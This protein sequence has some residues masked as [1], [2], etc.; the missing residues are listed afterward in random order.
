MNNEQLK[1][2]AGAVISGRDN[3][4]TLSKVL[5]G[6]AKVY[7]KAM[8][9]RWRLYQKKWLKTRRL[10]CRIISV[11][12]LT[13]GGTGK[14]PMTIYMA[15]FLKSMGIDP[16]IVCRGYKG[17][18]ERSVGIVTDGFSMFLKPEEAGDEAYL[19][20]SKLSGVPVVVG[21]DRY[22]SGIKAFNFFNP[23]VIILDDGFQYLRLF[24]DLNLLLVDAAN[25]VG[26]GYIFPRGP[27][28]EPSAH[29]ERADALVITRTEAKKF[30]PHLFNEKL[31]V[32]GKPIFRCRH[33]PD[34]LSVLTPDHQWKKCKTESIRDRKC[35]AFSGI[36]KNEDF[37]KML[38]ELGCRVEDF[39]AFADHHKFS[40][41][42]VEIVL[43]KA[44]KSGVE[45]LITTEK[46]RVKLPN[47]MFSAI[48]LY[49]L[50]VR[51]SFIGEDKIRFKKFVFEKLL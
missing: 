13:L 50:G 40:A 18:Y 37:L 45:F 21:K 26:N 17:K 47:H 10:P 28:R 20:A 7:G 32:S 8:V 48:N 9:L 12:N 15:A 35:V 34:V 1:Q 31:R 44:I 23:D 36:A 22:A 11:G 30:D 19:M 51:I 3:D 14:T 33:V 39:V 24:R 4:S 27:L 38:L 29:L 16:A 49:S 2:R 42:D 46:D 41:K 5:G 6:V 43:N 25:P